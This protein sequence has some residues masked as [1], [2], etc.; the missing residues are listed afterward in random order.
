VVQPH[1]E[2]VVQDS[3]GYSTGFTITQ[4]VT[5]DA[6]GF[7]ASV[8]STTA[9]DLC[10]INATE[11]EAVILRG[12]SFH[13]AKLGN[14]AIVASQGCDLYVEH[15][16]I[17]EFL[18][19]GIVSIDGQLWVTDTD[20][21]TCGNGIGVQGDALGGT[22]VVHNSRVSHCQSG[23]FISTTGAGNI[24][25]LASNCTASLCTIGF[26]IGS[27]SS[28]SADMTLDS[29]R[30]LINGGGLSTIAQSTG[31]ATTRLIACVVEKNGIGIDISGGGPGIASVLG[32]GPGTRLIQ[33][34]GLGL[35][36]FT[37]LK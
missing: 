30:S 3:G 28:G 20:V 36:G 16:S 15:C 14:N 31:N 23:F 6:A 37:N 18:G 2:L 17:S 12:I 13:G 1:G 11:G 32:T 7:N 19:D 21:R 27:F 24:V 26:A 22:L 35:T 10:T 9:T 8:I 4:S 29:C 34:S 33:D 5:I 25:G